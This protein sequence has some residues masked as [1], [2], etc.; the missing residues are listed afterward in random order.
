MWDFNF[1]QEE[2]ISKEQQ[3]ELF[4][5]LVQKALKGEQ[6]ESRFIVCWEDR[7]IVREYI[8]G[9]TATVQMFNNLITNLTKVYVDQIEKNAQDLGIMLSL[10]Q[11]YTCKEYYQKEREIAEDM[12]DEYRSY[13]FGGHVW[14][15][16]VGNTRK[17]EDMVD[18]R[19]LPV[20]WF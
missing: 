11:F 14:D 19:T 5:T 2:Q 6:S 10:K 13:I 7:N 20:K 4:N 17:E 18:Y 16:L 12:L 8:R 3:E 15:T 1:N 9:T